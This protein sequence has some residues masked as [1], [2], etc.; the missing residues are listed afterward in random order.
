MSGKALDPELKL[1][2]ATALLEANGRKPALKS[3]MWAA[4]L[5]AWT[6]L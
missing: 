3:V 1:A 2:R 5:C 6:L 4:R